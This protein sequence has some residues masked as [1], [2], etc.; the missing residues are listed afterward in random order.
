MWTL[1]ETQYTL[2]LT[3][4]ENWV[5]PDGV[6]KAKVMLVNGRSSLLVSFRSVTN[7]SQAKFSVCLGCQV[8]PNECLLTPRRPHYFGRLG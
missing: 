6:A 2:N 8:A 4:E 3:E 7:F 1:T 5:G